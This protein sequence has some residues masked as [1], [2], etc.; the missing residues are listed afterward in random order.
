MTFLGLLSTGAALVED[1][2][3]VEEFVL[4]PSDYVA[5]KKKSDNTPSTFL[6]IT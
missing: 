6:C 5:K 2:E 3:L 1:E 4:S